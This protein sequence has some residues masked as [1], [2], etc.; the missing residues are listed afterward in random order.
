VNDEELNENSEI[1]LG[2]AFGTYVKRH[3][4]TDTIVVGFDF[5]EYTER[6]KNAF[7]KGVLTTGVNVVDVGLCLVPMLYYAQYHFKTVAGT[8]ITGSHNENG[9]SGVKFGHGYSKTLL[10]QELQELYELI[11]KDDFEV[12]QGSVRNDPI[13]GPYFEMITKKV[14]LSRHIKVVVE[15]G[16]GTA[17]AFAPKILRAVGCEVYELFC[18]L[19]A[20][21]PHHN[22][23]PELAEAKRVLGEE[24]RRVGA[25]IG[26]A[27]D[28][29]GD[30][31]GVCDERGEN[32]WSDRLLILLS[33]QALE[34]NPGGKVIF[35]VKCTQALPEDIKVHG[36]VPMMWKT[37]HSYIKRKAQEE[38]AVL[39]G[40]RSGHF[41]IRDDYYGYD[42]SIMASLRLL[43]YYDQY[44]MPFSELIA[45]TPYYVM[46]PTIHIACADDNKYDVIA[47]LTAEFI[48]EYGREN[49][50]DVNGARVNFGDGWGLVRASSNEPVLVVVI[51]AKTQEKLDEIKRIFR[52]KFKKYPAIDAYWKNE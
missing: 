26:M 42:D 50:I 12:G 48:A 49:V 13:S 29:D 39:A 10:S 34:K 6:L 51:E 21:F 4:I 35:D 24:V 1:L 47:R 9:W 44:K 3:Q 5:R 11:V 2:K 40:E 43:A 38:E 7:V 19:D 30:R 16:N 23:N 18:N 45:D 22:P 52:E 36:G 15:C 8:M 25:E 41:F 28:G 27:Y 32:V 17:G 46:T 20:T 14:T 33:R 37:G 31:L